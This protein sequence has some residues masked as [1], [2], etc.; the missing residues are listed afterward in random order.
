MTIVDG[1][2][3][4]P[5]P[6]A[7]AAG[8]VRRRQAEVQLFV[9]GSRDMMKLSSSSKRLSNTCF[10]VFSCHQNHVNHGLKFG[11]T[12]RE[13]EGEG[14]RAMRGG[15]GGGGGGG[16]YCRARGGYSKDRGSVYMS[17]SQAGSRGREGEN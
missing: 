4:R 13:N 10:L 11:E 5:Q 6:R 9:T 12:P 3:E 14:A 1:S 15:G 2:R 7:S 16:G 17:L 8:A